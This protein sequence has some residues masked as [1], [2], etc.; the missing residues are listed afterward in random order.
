MRGRWFTRPRTPG[1]RASSRA[2]GSGRRGTERA[3]VTVR[4]AGR[5]ATV[6]VVVEDFAGRRP[7]AFAGEVVPIFT[8][9]G[10]N[11]GACHGQG[12]RPER[13]P[14][15]ACSA[16]IPRLDYESLTR[17]GRGRRVFPL[18]AGVE[19]RAPEADG[20]GPPRRRAEVRR[21]VARVPDHRALDRAGDAVRTGAGADGGADRR[22]PRAASAGAGF[23]PA[24]PRDG[25]SRP[26][27]PRPT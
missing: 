27:A 12:E 14:A 6:R 7:V 1:S 20:P 22:Q 9:A 18:G 26:T 21:R 11:A 4:A 15:R 17:E 10:C 5:S 25:R 8:R 23:G 13:V 16:S 3:R 24:A 2:G 19:P